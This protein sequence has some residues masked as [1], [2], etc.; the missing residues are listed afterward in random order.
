MLKELNQYNK[1]SQRKRTGQNAREIKGKQALKGR[2]NPI[3]SHSTQA[4][5]QSL[6]INLDKEIN[7]H[8]VETK[9]PRT[10]LK[11]PSSRYRTRSL[12]ERILSISISIFNFC[13]KSITIWSGEV[14]IGLS[15][16]SS[17]ATKTKE[18]RN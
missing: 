17:L 7:H 13:Q 18:K 15:K 10:P 12:K 1:K 3:W 16:C 8:Q 6:W 14:Y 9:G 4:L 11:V 5:G 2:D